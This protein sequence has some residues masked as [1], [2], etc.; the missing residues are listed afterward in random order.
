MRSIFSTP[1][2]LTDKAYQFQ[3][4]I[5]FNNGKYTEEQISDIMEITPRAVRKIAEEFN[6]RKVIDCSN[7]VKYQVI[8]NKY[9]IVTKH[10]D[11]RDYVM[12]KRFYSMIKEIKAYKIYLEDIGGNKLQL[13]MSLDQ[14]LSEYESEVAK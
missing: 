3:V 6:F 1:K 12:T 2:Q 13:Q 10:S 14:L 4:L 11:S 7:H 9:H 5:T 8:D